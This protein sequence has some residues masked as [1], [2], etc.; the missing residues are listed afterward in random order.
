MLESMTQHEA[1]V[2]R[3]VRATTSEAANRLDAASPWASA[4]RLISHS[5]F[6][7]LVAHGR[8]RC[9]PSGLDSEA[10]READG[11]RHDTGQLGVEVWLGDD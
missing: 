9:G 6:D 11:D 1:E 4:L 10:E 3:G 2:L 7:S 5:L 8:S